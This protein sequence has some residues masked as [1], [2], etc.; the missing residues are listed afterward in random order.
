MD[1]KADDPGSDSWLLLLLKCATISKEMLKLIVVVF[2]SR[3]KAT[4]VYQGH[5]G[6]GS[7]RLA[8]V[9]PEQGMK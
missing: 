3:V 5:S 4:Y 9:S 1:V 6:T 7:L 8:P 2:C